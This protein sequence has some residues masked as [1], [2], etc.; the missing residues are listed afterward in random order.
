VLALVAAALS[1]AVAVPAVALGDTTREQVATFDGSDSDAGAFT[2]LGSVAIH[3][4]SGT[5]YAIDVGASVVDK[6]DLSGVAQ[7]FSALGSS[8]LDGSAVTAPDGPV[9]FELAALSGVAVD[10]SGTAS[11]GNLFVLSELQQTVW[12]FD[13]TGTYLHRITGFGDPCGVAVDSGGDVWVADYVASAVI[14]Y[15]A[16]GAATGNSIDTSGVGPP[17][18]IAFD[19]A[20][21]LYVAVYNGALHK[22]D[23]AG[24]YVGAIDSEETRSVT[25]DQARDQVYVVHPEHVSVYDAAGTE[26]YDLGIGGGGVAGLAIDEA[27]D[28]LYV[29]DAAVSAVR[30]FGP[31]VFVPPP[32]EPPLTLRDQVG[33]FDGADSDA[34]AFS[35][36]GRVAVHQE[37]GTVYAIDAGAG[38]VDKFDLSGVAQ[39]FSALGSSSLDGSAVTAPDGPVAFS[40]TNEGDVAVDNSG[41]ASDGNLV[42]LTENQHTVWVFDS[43]GTYLHRITG[44]G[45]PCGV[46]VDSGGD[47][48]VADF[49]AS[50]VI[51][52]DA[53]GAATGSSIDTSGVGGPCHIAFDSA[54]NLY[55]A[56]YNGALHKFDSAGAYVGPIDSE[57]TKSVA[58]DQTNDRVYVVHPGRVSVYDSAG[59]NLYDFASG[60]AGA[61]LIGVAIDEA[62]DR[63]YVANAAENSV[64]VFGPSYFPA[65]AITAPAAT[66]ITRT[67]AKL[68]AKVNPRDAET[69][70][71]FEYG[72]TTSYGTSFPNPDASVGAGTDP[73]SVSRFLA[74]LQPNTT[75]H[76]R[77]VA[78]SANG[79]VSSPD[80]TFTT[81]APP[82]GS[83][84]CPNQQ[85]R[86]GPSAA[87]P[88]CRA[89][90]MVSPVD[91]DNGDIKTLNDAYNYRTGHEQA[92][93]DG[94]KLTYSSY[95]AFGDAVSAPWTS[96]YIASRGSDGWSTHSI[97]PPRDTTLFDRPV[98][99]WDYDVQ[100]KAFTD[101]LSNAWVFNNNA[102]P[103]TADA[104]QGDVNLYRRDNTNDS[105]QAL[106]INEATPPS[107]AMVD[108][109]Q[110]HSSDGSHALFIDTT[111]Q[112]PDSNPDPAPGDFQL[113]EFTGGEIRLV[114]ILPDGT[115]YQGSSSAGG[116]EVNPIVDA[117]GRD[118]TATR[119]HA[120]SDDGSR[121][122]WT[123][124][125]G[126]NLGPGSLYVRIDGERTVPISTSGGVFFRAASADGSKVIFDTDPTQPNGAQSDGY[127]S[128]Y[129]FD[130][131]SGTQRLVAENERGV[132]GASDDLSYIYFVSRDDLA[133]GATA[134]ENNLYLDHD[135]EVTFVATLA[136]WDVGFPPVGSPS[137]ATQNVVS[138]LALFRSSRVTPDGRHIAFQ[139]IR[140][141]TGY[142][143]TDAV[144]GEA[145]VEVFTY[146]ADSGD[147][148]CASCNPSGAN[149]VGQA[150]RYPYTGRD[151]IREAPEEGPAT[152]AGWL[153]TSESALHY[154]RALSDD[155][156]RLF[157]N[158]FDA[159]VVGD[160]NGDQDVYQ[161]TAQGSGGCE[162]AGGCVS[163][164]S[165]GKGSGKSEFVDA[166]PDGED[167]FFTTGSSLV[168]EDDGLIDIYNARVGGGFA[169]R[170]APPEGCEGEGC[171]APPAAP[172]DRAP[173]S[174]GPGGPG[175]GPGSRKAVRAGVRI[176]G[177]KAGS[178]TFS[179]RVR[180]AGR[181]VITATGR[182][183]R[184]VRRRV[185]RAGT[186]RLSFKLTAKAKRRLVVG[187]RPRV[188]VRVRFAPR[189]GRASRASVVLRLKQSKQAHRARAAKSNSG[190]AK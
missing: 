149:P 18:R 15:D 91:K 61:S 56:L 32:V 60:I 85:F 190:G 42:V 55:V 76:W 14:E 45:D 92:S 98:S 73:V 158:S 185:G 49:N 84:N 52:Y 12:V 126:G 99:Q 94:D 186:Y 50:A 54:D 169:P 22:F 51:E 100:F 34:G 21:N 6:F 116:M 111:P 36:L 88:D 113:Y 102:T 117:S 120:I 10:N 171:Q 135:G 144:N 124:H 46:A 28:Q 121:I 107:G 145:D 23:S 174:S 157:F 148:M 119:D 163:L 58:V 31:P 154:P 101:D 114:S 43:T 40:L 164:I 79:T 175:N 167:V 70:Y 30:V 29:A 11:D 97:N 183:V 180:V 151:E 146:D 38:V 132:L 172:S 44:F 140:S 68:T 128:L 71:R 69:T 89:Y 27:A 153:T 72:T 33:A 1:V 141:L 80:R 86:T 177:K 155:G 47:V 156:S 82:T 7:D 63:A 182:G 160:T 77:I 37:S 129:L 108:D 16:S 176:V 5:V 188:R 74:G 75:Y 81:L 25:V 95:K 133:A 139:S 62:S 187:E 64:R 66:D 24:A 122:F 181:G 189:S 9:S 165:S 161:W 130:V 19:S 134:G 65:P 131:D 57:E 59:T 26:L 67:E 147:L 123:A 78:T 143:N 118:S 35:G 166:S 103:L 104:V 159:L 138:R 17:C 152:A 125:T 150:L 2:N 53:S 173:A 142:D 20:D 106:T 178:T 3:Q 96:Q 136:P 41:T 8:S 170:P 162:R 105:Y 137:A 4:D 179:L 13:S 109:F 168:A 127:G 112:T 115:A 87:L 90:E 48:W 184:G 39:D 83:A 110:G 93:L